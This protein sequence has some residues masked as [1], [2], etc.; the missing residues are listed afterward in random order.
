MQ[1]K[2]EMELNDNRLYRDIICI[3]CPPKVGSTS[4]VTSIRLCAS[5]KYMVFHTHDK[6]IFKF[7]DN[8][9]DICISDIIRNT[10]V[11]NKNEERQRKVILID[12][13]RT[14]IERKISEYFEEI[15]FTHFNNT[16]ENIANFDL[17]K[18]IERFNN[19]YNKIKVNYIGLLSQ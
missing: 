14:P 4:L 6:S 7:R 1:Q 9:K 15:A 19:I 13:Y 2:N 11:Y 8:S 16:E 12:I 3:Y 18:I 17:S 5:S 10:D